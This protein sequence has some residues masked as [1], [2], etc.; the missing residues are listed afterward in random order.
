MAN[1]PNYDMWRTALRPEPAIIPVLGTPV[2]EDLQHLLQ[3]TR[4]LGKNNWICAWRNMYV[5]K[6]MIDFL[7]RLFV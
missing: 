1:G 2:A 6:K 4:L 3:P 5:P 7:H